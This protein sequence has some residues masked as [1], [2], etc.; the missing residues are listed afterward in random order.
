MT[1]GHASFNPQCRSDYLPLRN[2]CKISMG[3]TPKSS[4]SGDIPRTKHQT[5][6]NSIRKPIPKLYLHSRRRQMS[7]WRSPVTLF[8]MCDQA[9][10]HSNLEMRQKALS[11]YEKRD[12]GFPIVPFRA[13][14]VIS[15]AMV[16]GILRAGAR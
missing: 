16:W 4:M 9:R 7:Y 1:W 8:A 6:V 15:A 10:C 11:P 2:F 3:P 13:W 5:L 12:S 14:G